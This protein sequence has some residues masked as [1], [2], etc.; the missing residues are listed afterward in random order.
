MVVPIL[1]R[2]EKAFHECSVLFFTPGR[3]K[4]D[5]QC[6]SLSS[7]NPTAANAVTTSTMANEHMPTVS[8]GNTVPLLNSDMHVWKFIPP[9]EITVIE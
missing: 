4:V 7:I 3:F 2:N 1:N 5:I 6:R 8:I 9:V